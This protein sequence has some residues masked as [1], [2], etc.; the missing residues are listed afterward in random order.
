MI[1]AMEILLHTAEKNGNEIALR[2][3][4]HSVSY[5]ELLV[6]AYQ[7]SDDIS[8][9]LQGKNNLIMVVTNKTVISV[10][11]FW[12][13]IASGNCYI[14]I[15]DKTPINRFNNIISK[16]NPSLVIY[17]DGKQTDK[18]ETDIHSIVLDSYL[19]KITDHSLDAMDSNRKRESNFSI[20]GQDPLYL[21]F[22]S[23]STGTPKAIV[24]SHQSL[25]Q[26]VE[27]FVKEFDL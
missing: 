11:A 23:G 18:L 27:A 10:V 6:L 24:K 25:L 9:R 2:D 15:D 12:G 13:I 20:I 8:K 4:T 21:V 22:T 14:A 19:R 5:R 26:F 7:I 17:T 3:E 16:I 1:S